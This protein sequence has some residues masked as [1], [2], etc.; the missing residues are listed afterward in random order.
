V[1]IL[2]LVCLLT[3]AFHASGHT[4]EN[5]DLSPYPYLLRIQR[6][7]SG[8]R[9][10]ILL[11][12]SGDYH[13][14]RTTSDAT[15]VFE[16]VLSHDELPE[17]RERLDVQQLRNLSKKDIAI[18]L[19]V[20]P[21]DEL[22]INIFRG[23]HWQDLLFPD[24]GSQ[25]PFATS[26]GPL[27]KWFESLPKKPYRKLTEDE[28]RNNCLTPKKIELKVR[29]PSSTPG[30]SQPAPSSNASDS[31]P[32]LI[33][34]GAS[35]APAPPPQSTFLMRFESDEF[36]GTEAEMQCVLIYSDG[37]YHM[38]KS[39]QQSR[40]E[41]KSQV[42]EG[43]IDSA[44]VRTLQQLLD[45]HSLKKMEQMS[46]KGTQLMLRGK[47]TTLTIFRGKDQAQHLLFADQVRATGAGRSSVSGGNNNSLIRPLEK[48]IKAEI[49]SIKS[50][51]VNGVTPNRCTPSK[52]FPSSTVSFP[53]I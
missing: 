24:A 5:L 16:S 35:D 50:P 31:A 26:L 28:G 47:V 23:D 18:S 27:V 48:W 25:R 42:Y 17:V 53:S 2:S 51:S 32:E 52:P 45:D 19:M 13:L 7:T 46:L 34:P 8:L 41:I 49:L 36:S 33:R 3:V 1:R 38:E 20:I 11:Q 14:E 22:Q 30:S 15:D 6:D 40:S 10:C 37:R 39:S 4:A 43:S 12:Q 44:K 21:Y 9:T 29:G